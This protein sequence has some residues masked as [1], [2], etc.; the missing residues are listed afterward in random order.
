MKTCGRTENITA[1]ALKLQRLRGQ[2][3]LNI[4][5]ISLHMIFTGNPGTGKTT[6]AHRMSKILF[7]L[8][9]LS[10]GHLVETNHAE[11]VAG[12]PQLM[13]KF[14]ASNPDLTSQFNKYIEFHDYNRE[15]LFQIFEYT[16]AKN[17]YSLDA[18]AA[19]I[20]RDFI[21]KLTANKDENFGNARTMRNIFEQSFAFHANRI[22]SMKKIPD[23]RR[24]RNLTLSLSAV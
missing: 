13:E 12:Y 15:E 17:S 3:G 1:R 23:Y 6:V 24:S 20:L 14:I 16:C 11:M 9:Y 22:M 4:P 7:E 8:G 5:T 10:K 18:K 21:D 19:Q 2:R